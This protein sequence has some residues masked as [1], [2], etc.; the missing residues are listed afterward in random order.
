ML[1]ERRGGH[2]VYAQGQSRRTDVRRVRWI[3]N[4]VVITGLRR[5]RRRTKRSLFIYFFQIR[6]VQFEYI[7]N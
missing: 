1:D 7:H 5:R 6:S 4:G 3:C 2:P